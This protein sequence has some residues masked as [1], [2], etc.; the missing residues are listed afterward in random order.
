MMAEMPVSFYLLNGIVVLVLLGLSG[1]I[2]GSEVAFFSFTHNQIKEFNTSLDVKEKRISQLLHHPKRLLATILILNNLVNIFIVTI[3]TFATWQI[4]GDE[5]KQGL[6]IVILTSVITVLIIFFGEIIPKV[7]ANHNGT[8]FAKLTSGLLLLSYKLFKP[9]S[10]FLMT[11]TGLI[12]RRMEKK[13]YNLSV[14]EIN[15][16]LEISV[17]KEEVTD[18]EKG[19]LKGI[20]N[21]GTL[22]VKQVMKSRMDITAID[23]ETHFHELMNQINKTGYSRIPIFTET[24]DKIDGILY[25]KDLLP[26]IG[27]EEDFEWQHLLRPAYFVPESKKIDDLFKD[28]QEKQVHIAVVI[29]E[30]GG[31]SGLIT[32]ED[33]IEEIVGEINDEFDD[34]SDVAYNKLD[35]QTY[36]FEGKTSLNDFCKITDSDISLFDSVKGESESLGGLL[37][38]INT[39]LPSAGEK[40][41]FRHFVFTVVAVDQRRIKRL[42]VYINSDKSNVAGFED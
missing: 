18:E 28:F 17:E 13:G 26:H 27:E 34:E 42:R 41:R 7:Y 31:T 2:S 9:I 10:W 8:A 36:I 19:I 40:I 12:E 25:I 33:V 5:G 21:F 23:R 37:L 29:D 11:I 38:E 3:S 32:M 1:L 6:T 39:K 14:E 24:V 4:V 20:V 22:S 35:N 30:Y 16:A 15:Q